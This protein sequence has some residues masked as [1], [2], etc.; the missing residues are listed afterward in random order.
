MKLST[1]L[2]STAALVVAGSAYAADLPAKKAAPAA[3]AG[4]PAFGAGFFQIPGG[5]TC[6]KISGYARL[7]AT[8]TANQDRGTTPYTLP[9]EWGLNFDARSNTD[10]GAL[11]SYIRVEDSATSRAYVQ[12]GGLTA[13]AADGALAWGGG[14]INGIQYGGGGTGRLSYSANGFTVGITEAQDNNDNDGE[15]GSSRPDIFATYSMKAGAVAVDLGAV[16][17]EVVGSASGS[18]NGYA[19][20]GH[21]SF[22]AGPATVNGYAAYAQGASAYLGVDTGADQIVADSSTTSSEL[23]NGSNLAAWID[24]PVGAGTLDLYMGRYSVTQ[25]ATTTSATQYEV[26]YAFSPVKGLTVTPALAQT[27]TDGD[28]ANSAFLRIQRDF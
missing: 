22:A 12:L 17:H 1:L 18:A 16:S 25:D 24:V 4:C 23:S 19:L 15:M 20:V 21:A 26:S 2:L 3:V 9:G 10:Q 7:D 11:R 13:G 6:L 5:D 27:T 28:T 8:Y 14:V